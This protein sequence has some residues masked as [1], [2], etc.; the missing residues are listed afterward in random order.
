MNSGEEAGKPASS[1]GVSLQSQTQCRIADHQRGVRLPEHRLQIGLQ[2]RRIPAQCASA[3]AQNAHERLRAARAAIEGD[4]PNLVYRLLRNQQQA[5]HRFLRS[6]GEIRKNYQPVD[7]LQFDGGDDRNVHFARAE[8]FRTLRRHRK[9]KLIL[10]TLRS[11]RKS[12]HQRR[13][14][15]VLHNRDAERIHVVL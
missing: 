3:C 12:P 15:E 13:S 11:V 6:D 4:A 7:P 8:R 5:A 1:V 10:A 2:L 9:R 14:I